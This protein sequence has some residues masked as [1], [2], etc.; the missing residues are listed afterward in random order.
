MRTKK[1]KAAAAACSRRWR[2]NNPEKHRKLQ[3]KYRDKTHLIKQKKEWAAS[4][5]SEEK[6][7]NETLI[8]L[9]YNDLY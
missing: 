8:E 9:G 6:A 4:T 7:W 2:L 1:Q 5:F 3:K